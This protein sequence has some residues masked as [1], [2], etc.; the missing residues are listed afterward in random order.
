MGVVLIQWDWCPYQRSK[1]D[2]N[3]HRIGRHEEKQKDV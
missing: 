1:L 2:T 3:T